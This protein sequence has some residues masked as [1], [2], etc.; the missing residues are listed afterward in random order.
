M[1]MSSA[2]EKMS[3]KQSKGG[4]AL[5]HV[6][7]ESCSGFQ[8][9][10]WRK[11]CIA[12]GCSAVDHAPGSD[13]EDDQQMGR[14]LADSPYA[15]LTAK[16]KGG[17]GLRMYKRNR[18]I[19]TNPVVSRKDPTFNTTTYDWAPAG[20]NQ[21]LAMQYMELIPESQRPVS[22]T[23]GGLER[24]RQLFRQLPAYDQDPMKCQSLASEEEISSMLLFVKSYKQEVLGVGEVALPGEDGALKEAAS[25]RTAK[26]AKDRSNSDKKEHQDHGSTNS[27]TASGT[28]STN[29]TD[30]STK[31]GYRCTGCH[32]E[33]AKESPAV[34]AERA[35]YRS[36]L[37]HPTCFV[38]S[39]CGH[40]LVD[41][42]YFWSNQKLFCGRHYCQTV[43]PR[44]SGCDELIF[45]RSF[46]TA[47]DGRMWHHLHY[48]CWK[49]G[50]NL[51]T[52]CQH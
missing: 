33:V 47:K 38:C 13:V 52:P 14:L 25:Q 30:D 44:C 6:C 1:D 19:V 35:G 10:S 4:P 3:V 43:W 36:A 42:V 23:D 32:G 34:Y 49:C 29:G 40:G 46:H 7:E 31:T 26:E 37:W 20:L 18:M 16:V 11:V 12:C 39:E 51:D 41:L 2:M 5:C 50:Q 48:C 22:G 8:P 15:H 9:H 17:G 45:C 27:G 28:G 21:T 24:R